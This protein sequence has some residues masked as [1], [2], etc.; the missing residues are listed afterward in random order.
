MK[1]CTR[2]GQRENAA[3]SRANDEWSAVFICFASCNGHPDEH[4]AESPGAKQICLVA[5]FPPESSDTNFD[6]VH[7]LLYPNVKFPTADD[8]LAVAITGIRLGFRFGI[9]A[10]AL[11][12]DEPATVVASNL[13]S[14]QA[15]PDQ[16]N[17]M[18]AA[19]GIQFAT[20]RYGQ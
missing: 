7:S 2:K 15:R 14:G 5:V 16:A 17:Y 11:P 12:S 6:D 20:L 4:V 13:F 18:L 9:T 10:I 19:A 3:Y 8:L 1:R